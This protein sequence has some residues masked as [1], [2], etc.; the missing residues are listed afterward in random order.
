MQSH[1]R[2]FTVRDQVL[3][4]QVIEP[5]LVGVGGQLGQVLAEVRPALG[6]AGRVGGVGDGQAA[7]VTA[8][9]GGTQLGGQVDGLAVPAARGGAV[10]G[11]GMHEQVERVGGQAGEHRIGA[12][13]VADQGDPGL[14]GHPVPAGRGVRARQQVQGQLD[15][16]QAEVVSYD[17][18]PVVGAR[19]PLDREAVVD[20]QPGAHLSAHLRPPSTRSGPGS[21]RTSRRTGRG[22]GG[23]ARR[24]G[25]G[26][27]RPRR[28]RRR[29]GRCR[30]PGRPASRCRRRWSRRGRRPPGFR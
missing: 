23:P 15:G 22:G 14:F 12:Q 13:A 25:R 10:L 5:A 30:R 11:V 20:A 9:R 2:R 1:G 16:V 29:L 18:G 28:P 7:D 26:G 21:G 17:R 6:A 19:P 4:Q 24:P 27:T 8:D 3:D